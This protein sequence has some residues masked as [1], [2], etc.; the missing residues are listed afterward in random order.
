M[1]AVALGLSQQHGFDRL[2][3]GLAVANDMDASADFDALCYEDG[4]TGNLLL[5]SHVAIRW[6][7][8]LR[9]AVNRRKWHGRMGCGLDA[10]TP[11]VSSALPVSAQV[12]LVHLPLQGPA[13]HA[14]GPVGGPD[15][16]V[17][18]YKCWR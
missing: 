16:R 11:L 3:V 17:L 15:A 5:R 7:A 12:K 4:S 6:I 9:M 2:A 8:A 1:Q 18:L 13:Q 10:C 14:A